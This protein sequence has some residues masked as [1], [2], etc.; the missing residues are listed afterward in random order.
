MARTTTVFDYLMQPVGGN[1]QPIVGYWV[2]LVNNQ[3]ST[4]YVSTGTTSSAGAFTV[5]SVP[6]GS[7]TVSTSLTN[8]GPWTSTGDANYHVSI[9]SSVLTSYDVTWYGAIGDGV[10]DDTAAIQSAITACPDGGTVSFPPGIYKVTGAGFTLGNPSIQLMGLGSWPDPTNGIDGNSQPSLPAASA[11][12]AIIYYTG[13]GTLFT[14]NSGDGI[15][16]FTNLVLWGTSS[17]Q[18]GIYIPPAGYS[19]ELYLTLCLFIGWTAGSTTTLTASINNS[20]DPVTVSTAAAIGPSSGNFLIAIDG[21]LLKVTSGQGTTTMTA[22]R[23]QELT[24]KISHSNG[25]TVTWGACA[26]WADDTRLLIVDRCNF[27]WNFHGLFVNAA[28]LKPMMTNSAFNYSTDWAVKLQFTEFQ[29][30]GNNLRSSVATNDT[31]QF[32]IYHCSMWNVSGNTF[33]IYATPTAAGVVIEGDI[34]SGTRR[35][36]TRGWFF[37]GNGV[38]SNI[39]H[40]TETN[41]PL[42]QLK[43]CVREGLITGNRFSDDNSSTQFTT[44]SQ[45]VQIVNPAQSG[46]ISNITLIANQWDNMGLVPLVTIPANATNI[47]VLANGNWALPS[48]GG[49][50]GGALQLTGPL[51]SPGGNLSANSAPAP[52]GLA[53]TATGTTGSTT[54]SYYVAATTANGD[55]L[56]SSTV[57]ITN[58]NATLSSTN[59][60]NLSWNVSPMATGYK[61]IRTAG[62][63]STGILTTLTDPSLTIYND[64]GATASGYSAATSPPNAQFIAQPNIG[65]T[66]DWIAALWYAGSLS[67]IVRHNFKD[68]SGAKYYQIASDFTLNHMFFQSDTNAICEFNRD[69]STNWDGK[70]TI[71]GT[72]TL[73]IA[74]TGSQTGA[75]LA[76]TLNNQAGTITTEALT[77]AAQGFSTYTVTNSIVAATSHVLCI[78]RTGGTNTVESVI[79]T[80]VAPASG[81]FTVHIYNSH[82]TNALNGTI[83]FDFFVFP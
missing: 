50:L 66:T 48:I 47:A 52:T 13:T 20:S 59:Y 42:L 76:V 31:C 6:Y 27:S 62:G 83:K 54:Y 19:P 51:T 60:N 39:G 69:G 7:Y 11:S 68:F 73:G 79:M 8:T 12:P 1:M 38:T 44:T 56:P 37:G 3:T 67:G 65:T 41:N 21:E 82:P 53:V 55:T 29:F 35:W 23:A 49:P 30:A 45:P 17:A 22:S 18:F 32:W 74:N 46:D 28:Q 71:G 57:T 9:E 70:M 36:A 2:R 64:T 40:G 26:V 33:D 5:N 34:P 43:G 72:A 61:V 25:A 80:G 58:G 15:L 78:Y 14:I 10:A 4:A 63:G 24:P 75:G 16:F 81:S 77:T